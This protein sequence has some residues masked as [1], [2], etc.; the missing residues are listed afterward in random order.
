MNWTFILTV[1]LQLGGPEPEF[2]TAY[3]VHQVWATPADCEDALKRAQQMDGAPMRTAIYHCGPA[4]EWL[5]Q[6]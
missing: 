6:R 1:L 4:P 3:P 5:T 2:V